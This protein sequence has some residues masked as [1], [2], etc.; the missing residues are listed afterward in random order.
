MPSPQTLRHTVYYAAN[1][2][3]IQ[4]LAILL[5]DPKEYGRFSAFYLLLALAY[6]IQLSAIC[7][8]WLRAGGKPD[9]GPDYSTLLVVLSCLISFAC[10]LWVVVGRLGPSYFCISLA[11][12]L[13]TY[14]QGA[15]YAAVIQR[16]PSKTGPGDFW[17]L[18]VALGAFL[19]ARMI[20]RLTTI[21]SLGL[22]WLLGAACAVLLSTAPNLRWKGALQRWIGEHSHDIERLLADSAVL[23]FGTILFPLMFGAF[24]GPSSFGVYRA[25]GSAAVLVRWVLNPL[26][27]LIGR[28]EQAFYR[29]RKVL[30]GSVIA[31]AVLGGL[32]AAGLRFILPIALPPSSVLS[33]LGEQYS[34]A[35]AV[36]VGANFLET[37][38]YMTN[39]VYLSGSL[40]VR[41]RFLLTTIT[42][43]GPVVGWIFWGVD[44]AVWG[45]A[46]SMVGGSV[47]N[48]AAQRRAH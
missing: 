6:S 41:T 23:D 3:V 33:L 37:V 5:L 13:S 7:E 2:V 21:S 36:Y 42:V 27:P 22:A 11:I 14:R 16:R 30:I 44:G 1:S 32:T 40:L 39:R 17:G 19:L 20:V 29:G 38:F 18:V 34:A 31:A 35:V 12:G 9:S 25:L 10:L 47:V 28:R 26:R 48:A 24:V 46:A 15:R 4:S 43:T 8:P 45:A